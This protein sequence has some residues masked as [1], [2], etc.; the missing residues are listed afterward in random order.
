M[1]DISKIS[2]FADST[3][4]NALS[5]IDSGAVKIALVVDSDNK[6]LGTLCDGDIRRAI[7]RKKSL[8]DTIEDVYFRSPTIAKKG[9]S[10]EDLLR[11]CSINGISQVPIVDE[12]RKIIDLFIIDDELLKRQHENHVVLMVGGAWYALKAIN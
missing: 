8:N 3:I 7:L 5:V 2:L 11:L 1:I 12:D 4:V 6:L 9:S 10:K